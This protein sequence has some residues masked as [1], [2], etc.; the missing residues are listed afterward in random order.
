MPW[1]IG[2]E[3]VAAQR[4][5]GLVES[6]LVHSELRPA[7]SLVSI[8]RLRERSEQVDDDAAQQL[9]TEGDALSTQVVAVLDAQLPPAGSI[10]AQMRRGSVFGSLLPSKWPGSKQGQFICSRLRQLSRFGVGK[11]KAIQPQG[12]FCTRISMPVEDLQIQIGDGPPLAWP[13]TYDVATAL[14]ER[15]R[16]AKFG[17]RDQTLQDERVRNTWEIP[18]SRVKIDKRRWNKTLHPLLN[19]I[20]KGL[21]LDMGVALTA[22]LHNMLIY[23]V[24]QF[25]QPHQDSE[26]EEGMVATLVIALPCAHT[27]GSLVVDHAGTR[28]RVHTSRAAK[29][30]LT[31]IAFYAD[32]HHEVKRV[33]SGYRVVLTYNLLLTGAAEALRPARSGDADTASLA[34]ALGDYFDQCTD[35][36][37]ALYTYGRRQPS[38]PKWVYLLDHQYT[39]KSLR[40]NQ[41]KNGDGLKAD[42][43]RSLLT[44]VLV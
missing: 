27:G 43:C 24:G 26:K 29:D 30:K 1:P 5:L 18:K 34:R 14:I 33:T 2:R 41:L 19:D 12:D 8:A 11:V 36:P 42:G 10:A 16:P 7:D 20:K 28:K 9:F 17:W 38:P 21:G 25:F 15:A 44:T 23:E 31:C 37:K 3:E 4:G 13:L 40:W 22:S 6:T 39:E 32:C 35:E